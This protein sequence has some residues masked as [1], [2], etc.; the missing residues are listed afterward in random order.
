MCYRPFL[1]PKEETMRP[2]QPDLVGVVTDSEKHKVKNC[3]GLHMINVV[4]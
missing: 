2:A 4:L 3:D 1:A